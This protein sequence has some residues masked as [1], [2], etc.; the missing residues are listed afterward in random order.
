MVAVPLGQTSYKRAGARNA[1]V[2][3]INMLVEAD[4]TN[5][6]TGKTLI[7]RP[8]LELHSTCGNQPGRGIFRRF[9]VVNGLYYIVA[10][11][12]LYGVDDDGVSVEIGAIPG[13]DIVQMDGNANRLI[14]VAEGI[15]WSY[16]GSTIT[17]INMPLAEEVSSV[18]Y[19]KGYFVLV[20]DRSQR[21]YWLAPGDTDPDAL[22]FASVESSSDR[23]IRAIRFLDEL[24]FFGQQTTE[25]WQVTG[26]LDAPFAPLGGRLY[27]K[28]AA[29]RNC[30]TTT[31]NTLFWVGNDLTVYRAETSP[32]RISDHTV[33]EVLRNAG[34]DDLR[35]W[36]FTHDGH[37]IYCLRIADLGTY[38]FDVENANWPRFQ[39]YNED[40]WRAHLGTQ[41]TADLIVAIDDQDG[42]VWRLD[43]T[44]NTDG[45]DPMEREITGGLAVIGKP[46]KNSSI[47]LAM[48]T[49]WAPLDL[50]DP[51]IL[52]KFS[53]DGG[54]TWSSWIEAKVGLTGQY[55]DQ[56]I[57]RQLGSMS[58]P[59][60]IFRFRCTDDF[61]FRASYCR[62]NEV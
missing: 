1:E 58:A 60:R 49:G 45:D 40:T 4:P 50:E 15:A 37:T 7:Q 13:S 23:I 46:I 47:Y 16:D 61:P 52:M 19:I 48:A 27:D 34:I 10:G 28:G 51:R 26:N 21:F 33:E 22:N 44:I 59:G 9:G 29:N 31:D 54:N 32:V 18:A 35:A 2:A 56:A 55:K 12:K 36:A 30:I 5:Q 8:G 57:W 11:E 42:S 38:S 24:W 62:A 3:L 14:I 41:V 20:C 17:Q 39:S 6:V 43:S 25:I 53:D